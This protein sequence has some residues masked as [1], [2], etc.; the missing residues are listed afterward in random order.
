MEEEARL[1]K[2]ATIA[3]GITDKP[4]HEQFAILAR[5]GLQLT[6]INWENCNTEP[7]LV[8]V[9]PAKPAMPSGE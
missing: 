3:A 6:D 7:G 8:Y 4:V 5:E 1:A 9:I 2:L